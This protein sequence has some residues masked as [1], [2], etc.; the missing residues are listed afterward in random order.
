MPAVEG[1]ASVQESDR[2]RL[3]QDDAKLSIVTL[4][5]TAKGAGNQPLGA[6]VEADVVRTA[7]QVAK[8]LRACFVQLGWISPWRSQSMTLNE[9]RGT[10]L[11]VEERSDEPPSAGAMVSPVPPDPEVVAKP[12]RRRQFPSTNPLSFQVFAQRRSGC[13]LPIQFLI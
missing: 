11:G 7:V 3:S 6:D 2:G 5:V 12:T 9:Q 1:A 10:A 13:A 4:D 8:K